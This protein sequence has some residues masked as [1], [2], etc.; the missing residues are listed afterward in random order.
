MIYISILAVIVGLLAGLTAQLLIFLIRLLTNVFFHGTF[1]A[2]PGPGLLTPLSHPGPWVILMPVIGG[3]IIGLMARFGSRAVAGHGIP[4]AMEQVLT[5]ESRIPLRLTFLKPLSAAISIGTGAPYGAEGPIIATGGAMGSVVGQFLATT[6][7]ERKILLAA[8]ASAGIAAAFNAP[9]ASVLLAVELLLFEFRPKSL[10]PVG[11]ACVAAAL[12]HV[13]FEG[14]EPFFSFGHNT[15]EMPSHYAECIYLAIGAMVGVGAVVMTRTVYAIEHFFE[16]LPI[17]WMWHP[18]IGAIAVGIIGWRWPETFGSGYYNLNHLL[19]DDI[20]LRTIVVLGLMK[21]L[22]WTISLGSGTAGGTLAPVFTIGGALGG[23]MGFL[24]NHWFP[25]VHINVGVA[26]L[27][28]MVGIFA[29]AS[30]ALLTSVVF[31]VET[32]MQPATIM[33][34]L[35]G[36]AMAYLVSSLLMRH[37]IMTEKMARSGVRVPEEY[38]P[39]FLDRVLVR[40]VIKNNLVTLRGDDTLEN[41]RAWIASRAPGSTHQGYPVLGSN[42][43]LSGVVTRRDIL[44]PDV[45]GTTLVRDTIKRHLSVVFDDCTLRQAAD[46]MVNHDIGRLPVISRTDPTKLLG[47][48]T[49][50]DLL[51]V[52]RQRIRETS[53]AKPTVTLG[54]IRDRWKNRLGGTRAEPEH[55]HAK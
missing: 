37:S 51:A 28:G 53:E 49:R 13:A 15:V 55:A 44:D 29:G 36:C 25:G 34:A 16:H 10:I 48:V 22:S 17:H 26:A 4:E 20:T 1:T 12:M 11:L 21:F 38:H 6:A 18:A 41:V 2:Q 45:P 32:T 54:D 24:A 23:A 42:G 3:V 39:D 30:R 9:I 35:G 33:P 14:P 46:H 43:F 7:A 47:I 50:S 40:D 8:G 27:V 5:N 52:H 31:A 19:A